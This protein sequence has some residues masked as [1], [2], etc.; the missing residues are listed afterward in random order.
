METSSG[1][2]DVGRRSEQKNS[3]RFFL[4]ELM[5][6]QQRTARFEGFQ[7]LIRFVSEVWHVCPNQDA[8]GGGP[9]M[10]NDVAEGLGMKK[11]SNCT[12]KRAKNG[13]CRYR[14]ELFNQN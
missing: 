10:L 4:S 8:F 6:A 14:A 5:T 12:F 7:M 3:R 9:E 1:I 11:V 2:H 13:R